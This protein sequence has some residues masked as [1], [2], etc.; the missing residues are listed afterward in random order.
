MTRTLLLVALAGVGVGCDAGSPGGLPGAAGIAGATTSELS[1]AWLESDNCWKQ[2]VAG[3]KTCLPPATETGMMG[4][5]RGMCTFASGATVTFAPAVALPLPRD[6]AWNFTIANAGGECL[7]FETSQAAMKLTVHG[8]TVT[9]TGF[10][11][12]G[13]KITCPDGKS[14]V[15]FNATDLSSCNGGGPSSGLPRNFSNDAGGLLSFTLL[16][17]QSDVQLFACGPP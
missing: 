5:D 6:P 2:T 16:G 3:A 15:S 7:H 11:P 8:Q 9:Q 4:A 14:Y 12:T 1:C 10:D 13:V 17:A